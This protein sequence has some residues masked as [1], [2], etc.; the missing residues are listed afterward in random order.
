MGLSS[1][2]VLHFN[3]DFSSEELQALDEKID[4]SVN[5]ATPFARG[6]F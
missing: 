2:S 5:M 3:Q 4:M 1:A 6:A